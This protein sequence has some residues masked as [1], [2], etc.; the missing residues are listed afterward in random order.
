MVDKRI[1]KCIELGLW[2]I[3]EMIKFED[4]YAEVEELEADTKCR[5]TKIGRLYEYHDTSYG[6]IHK[7]SLYRLYLRI[8]LIDTHMHTQMMIESDFLIFSDIMGCY[9]SILLFGMGIIRIYHPASIEW[10]WRIFELFN[11]TIRRNNMR[12]CTKKN[13]RKRRFCIIEHINALIFISKVFI[14][15]IMTGFFESIHKFFNF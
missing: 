6:E 14:Q 9:D 15:Y 1:S 8:H 7:L 13:I 10:L 2:Y 5:K 11:A 3:G 12:K 4:M